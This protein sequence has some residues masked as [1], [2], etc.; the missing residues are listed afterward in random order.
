VT[1]P[2]PQFREWAF[3]TRPRLRRTAFLLTSDWHLAEDLA[4]D[5]LVRVHAVWSR[6][7]ASG[8]P[9]A[10]ATRTLVNC[11]R[12]TARRP[13]RRESSVDLLPERVDPRSS[14]EPVDGRDE[15]LAA[16]RQLGQSQRTVVVLRYWD[17]LS[18]D[19]VAA[20]MNLSSGTVK[21]QAA[22]ALARLRE[23]LTDLD[24]VPA[25]AVPPPF[26]R[27]RPADPTGDI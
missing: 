22:R 9:D 11:V 16:L 7:S 23:L 2:P 25:L 20:A 26:H 13:W 4:Q 10:Y 17:D 24:R 15:L 5:T 19:A 6:V 14:A 18:I 12:A 21:S 1:N 3:A 8:A 27:R